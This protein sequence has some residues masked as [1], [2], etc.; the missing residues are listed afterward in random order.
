VDLAAELL[1]LHK[2]GQRTAD[3]PH[4][5]YGCFI[6]E[7]CHILFEFHKN[8]YHQSGK[9]GDY[10]D[11]NRPQEIEPSFLLEKTFLL[12]HRNLIAG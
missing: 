10:Y 1:R 12:S 11:P 8:G 5:D 2:L 4:T 7:E 6:K 9:Q 3:K